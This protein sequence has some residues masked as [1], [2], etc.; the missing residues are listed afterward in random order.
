M[1]KFWIKEEQGGFG[2]KSFLEEDLIAVARELE[3]VLNSNEIDSKAI[4]ARLEAFNRNPKD[5]HKNH[6]KDAIHKLG[7]YGIYLRDQNNEI[8]NYVLSNLAKERRYAPVGNAA[9]RDGNKAT[10]GQGKAHLLDLCMGGSLSM[11]IQGVMD[12]KSKEDIK[13]LYPGRL[14]IAFEKIKSRIHQAK[15]KRFVPGIHAV[16]QLL[17]VDFFGETT[18]YSKF[19]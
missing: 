14:P 17:G 16:F 7:K 1:H 4:R 6:V 12:G 3:V 11:V 5:Y 10:I 9:F 2:F 8:L 13:A 18:S 19:T 15:I